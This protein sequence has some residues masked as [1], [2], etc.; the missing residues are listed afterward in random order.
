MNSL[1][2]TTGWCVG[3]D[4]TEP[5]AGVFDDSPF[6]VNRGFDMLVPTTSMTIEWTSSHG[7]PA[8]NDNPT[9]DEMLDAVDDLRADLGLPA[10]P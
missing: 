7:S 10:L 1:G 3:D 4:E 9:P 5:V 2:A 8:G 6:S